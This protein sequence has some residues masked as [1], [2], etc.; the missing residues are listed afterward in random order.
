MPPQRSQPQRPAAPATQR[1]T[2]CGMWLLIGRTVVIPSCGHRQ[3]TRVTDSSCNK[4]IPVVELLLKSR[5]L[6]RISSTDGQELGVSGNGPGRTEYHV[7]SLADFPS[8][9]KKE[10]LMWHNGQRCTLRREIFL[11]FSVLALRVVS[12][13]A[14]FNQPPADGSAERQ[15]QVKRQSTWVEAE[16]DPQVAVRATEDDVALLKTVL[17]GESCA[18]GR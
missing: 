6:K 13:G 4:T 1:T 15:A 2:S 17:S 11:S 10:L 12:L 8:L 18:N 3:F 5:K 14:E 9:Q 16:L 7:A